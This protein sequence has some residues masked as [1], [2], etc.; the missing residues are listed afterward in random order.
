MSKKIDFAFRDAA[1]NNGVSITYNLPDESFTYNMHMHSFFEIEIILNGSGKTICNNKTYELKS[2]LVSFLTPT[3]FHKYLPATDMYLIRIHFTLES[4]DFSFLESFYNLKNNV[5]YLNDEQFER[6]TTL[7][8]L[9]KN[10]TFE[11]QAGDIFASQVLQTLL[12]SLKNEFENASSSYENLPSSI[13]KAIIYIH[14]HFQENPKLK[15][16]ASSLF[17]SKNYFCSLFKEFMGESYKDYIRKLKLNH[18]ANL[19]LY[20][21]LPI[22]QIALSCGYDTQSNFNRDFKTFFG[23]SPRDMRK[24]HLTVNR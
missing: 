4:V 7:C 3:D 16:I 17:L 2:G 13:Q 1:V 21:D 23:I 11:G 12:H 5:I 24:K 9:L 20:S 10:N 15:D 18:A 22:T 14:S 8:H 6:I 19:L